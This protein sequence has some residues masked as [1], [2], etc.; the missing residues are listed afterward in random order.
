[1][2]AVRGRLAGRKTHVDQAAVFRR[3]RDVGHVLDQRLVLL[4]ELLAERVLLLLAIPAVL[5]VLDAEERVVR[6]TVNE[7]RRTPV[8]PQKHMSG[9]R[10]TQ[11]DRRDPRHASAQKRAHGTH[12]MAS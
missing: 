8:P 10:E 6:V 1:M 9:S 12:V 4:G 5:P 7:V 11:S 3:H 2:R